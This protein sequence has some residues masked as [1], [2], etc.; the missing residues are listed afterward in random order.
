M[1]KME[2]EISPIS[3]VYAVALYD[4]ALR[5][6]Q[7]V[8]VM[9][10]IDSLR[11]VV[12]HVPGLE[13]VLAAATISGAAKSA[14]VEKA[15]AS[16]LNPLTLETFRAMG[17]RDRLDLFADFIRA[18]LEVGR[19]RS[20]R[21]SVE[22]ITAAPLDDAQREVIARR[23]GEALGRQVDLN[24]TVNASLVGGVQLR[25]GD[26]FIDGS[27]QRRLASMREKLVYGLLVNMRGK[28][29]AMLES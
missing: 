21:V 11:Q 29:A 2:A 18:M 13:K 8:D 14:M 27:V 28:T 22:V 3:K 9:E 4:A 10:D 12:Q 15:F 20:N 23:T 6:S 25:I 19:E 17:R 24:A 7:L 16:R 5:A 1:E 26:L